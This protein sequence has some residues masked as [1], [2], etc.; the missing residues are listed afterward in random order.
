[1]KKIILIMFITLFS[2]NLFANNAK[3]EEILESIEKKD[4]HLIII[5]CLKIKD[6]CK[7]RNIDLKDYIKTDSVRLEFI[8]LK[9]EGDFYI[10]PQRLMLLTKKIDNEVSF[11]F[12]YNILIFQELKK[13]SLF[14]IEMKRHNDISITQ[15]IYKEREKFIHDSEDYIN[16]FY[17]TGIDNLI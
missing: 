17:L 7:V 10:I 16:L 5:T 11:N 12:G 6:I 2:V 1:M 8:D 13:D 3:V 15:S 14:N 9:E 4:N